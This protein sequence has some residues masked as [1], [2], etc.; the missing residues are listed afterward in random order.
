MSYDTLHN[1]HFGY[2]YSY[3]DQGWWWRLRRSP[4]DHHIV[5]R[6]SV[7][8]H[9]PRG[10]LGM[11][12]V[13]WVG[14]QVWCQ[15]GH[16]Y[17]HDNQVHSGA[18]NTAMTTKWCVWPLLGQVGRSQPGLIEIWDDGYSCDGA[19]GCAMSRGPKALYLRSAPSINSELHVRIRA[20]SE[21]N[22]RKYSKISMACPCPVVRRVRTCELPPPVGEISQALLPSAPSSLMGPGILYGMLWYVMLCH[23]MLCYGMICHGIRYYTVLDNLFLLRFSQVVHHWVD[24]WRTRSDAPSPGVWK[25]RTLGVLRALI[26]ESEYWA[27]CN[28]S[29]GFHENIV[30]SEWDCRNY[31]NSRMRFIKRYNFRKEF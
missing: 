6:V 5:R 29:I 3:Q 16:E 2:R 11:M 25:F 27:P 28:F 23:A 19:Q 8:A 9:F 4:D 15:R 24:P 14:R 30:I 21:Y 31:G 26:S 10:S 7:H 18:M 20:I 1:Y 17:S 12:D 13:G 22:V